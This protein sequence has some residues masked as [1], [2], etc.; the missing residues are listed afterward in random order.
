[1]ASRTV[2]KRLQKRRRHYSEARKGFTGTA[3][4][5]KTQSEPVNHVPKA[6]KDLADK[7]MN[8]IA[9]AHDR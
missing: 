1:M 2:L 5:E 9:R 4:F 8:C 7:T 3:L 6:A